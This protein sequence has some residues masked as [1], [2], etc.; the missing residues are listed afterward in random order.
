MLLI[1]VVL[2]ESQSVGNFDA[3]PDVTPASAPGA[4][5][6]GREFELP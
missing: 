2:H 5:A 1:G 6:A 4:A 3:R